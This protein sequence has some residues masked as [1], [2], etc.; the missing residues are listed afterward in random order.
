MIEYLAISLQLVIFVFLSFFPINNF[1]ASYLS[2]SLQKLN[3]INYFVINNLFLMTVLLIVSF[4]KLKI[5]YVF[6]II[7]LTYFILLLICLKDFSKYFILVNLPIIGIFLIINFALFID[8]ARD[9]HLA[10]DS[11]TLWKIKANSFYLGENYFGSVTDLHPQYPHLGSYI[12]AFFWKNSFLEFEYLGRLFSSYLHVLS[13]FAISSCFVNKNYLKNFLIVT[14]LIIFTYDP[15]LRGYQD[16]YIFSLITFF[17]FFMYQKIKSDTKINDF[18]ILI[19]IILPWIKNEGI[20]YSIFLTIIYFI[21][22]KQLI[23]RYLFPLIV[24]FGILFQFYLNLFYFNLNG[25][26]QFEISSSNILNDQSFFALFSKIWNILFYT[27][28]AFFKNPILIIDLLI[29]VACVYFTK[30]HKDNLPFLTFLVLN[31]FF[32]V[33]I[34]ILTP[35]D[36]KWH[37]QSSVDRLLLQTSGMYIY[38]LALLKD[39]KFFDI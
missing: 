2:K 17:G 22:Q 4:T 33:G 37:L 10:W 39:K 34:Y 20:F 14:L 1:T 29:I 15:T 16:V 35:Y 26:F 11:L 32:I 36:L 27:M 19:P 31:I 18:I 38:L 3:L 25:L 7:I 6:Y 23:K 21:F 9:L 13:L 28:H 5:D 12:W 8:I 30:L 24:F